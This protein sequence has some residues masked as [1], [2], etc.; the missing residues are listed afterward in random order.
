ME[1]FLKIHIGKR[2][3]REFLGLHCVLWGE[4]ERVTWGPTVCWVVEI[5]TWGPTVCWG[6]EIVTWGPT[7][8]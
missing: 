3:L 1:P 4:V 7:V 2:R 6:V 8:C 5:I